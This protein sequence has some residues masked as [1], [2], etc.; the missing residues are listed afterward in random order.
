MKKITVLLLCAM[1]L[2]SFSPLTISNAQSS[3][4]TITAKS[5]VSTEYKNAL[6]KAK[7]YN[8]TFYMSKKALYKQLTSKYGEGFSKKAATYAV[9]H[10]NANWNQNALRKARDYRKTFHMSKSNIYKQLVSSYGE[11]FT[12]S[13]AQYAI[14]HL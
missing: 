9:N 1:M 11:G 12:K 5:S 13:Q 14:K 6:Y 4:V 3:T 7:L 10:V 2:F 8:K